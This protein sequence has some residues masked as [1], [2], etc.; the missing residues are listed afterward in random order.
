MTTLITGGAGFIGSQ[1]AR[2]LLEQGRPVVLLDNL[3]PYYDPAFKRRN[4]A[5]VTG[6][7]FIEGDV[8]DSALIDR[9]LRDHGIREIVH[10]AA[11]AGVRASVENG[12][13]YAEVNTV[14]S[15]KLMDA[16]RRHGITQFV[17]AS[18]S[19]VYGNTQTIPFREDDAPDAPLAP[20]PASKRAAEIFAHSYHH[21]F[22]LNVSVLRFFNVYGP[23][24]R[25]DMMPLR[26]IDSILNQRSIPVYDGGTLQRDWTYIDDVVDGVA[27]ALDQPEGYAVYNIG[28]G[29]P[30]ALTDFIQ[31]YEELIGQPALTHTVPSPA[32]EPTITY[33]DNTRARERLGF[34]PKV[35]LTDGLARTWAWVREGLGG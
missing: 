3:D 7:T 21:L 29:E 2:A 15:V 24:G 20:Y 19:S 33:C 26:V 16:A 6:A 10:L 27:A 30:V 14:G 5:R 18:T 31:I 9:T 32:S 17:M 12:P 25:P 8:R 4:L 11:L 13:L 23:Y 22:G 1:L 35:A 28:R 34:Q